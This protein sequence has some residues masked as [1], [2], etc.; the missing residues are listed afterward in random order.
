MA[1][2]N[3]IQIR[4]GYS[5]GATVAINGYPIGQDGNQ[6][7]CNVYL[8]E[9]ELGYEIDTGKFKIGR[10]DPTTGSLISWCDL[11]YAGGGSGAGGII[12][13]SGIGIYIH[14]SGDDTLYSILTNTDNN[15]TIDPKDISSLIAGTS[16]SYYEI[17]LADNLSNINNI[18]IS[19][20]LSARSGIFSGD[21]EIAGNLIVQGTGIEFESATVVLTNLYV[22]NSGY[23]GNDLTV[24][25]TGVSLEGHRHNYDEIDGFCSGV[26]ECVSTQLLAIN[27]IQFT[28]A[29]EPLNTLTVA[30][31]GEALAQH[32]LNTTGFVARSGT[33]TYVTRSIAAGS[34][35]VVTNED[36]LLGNP[37][38]ALTG[39]VT[40]L[41]SVAAT[42]FSG[43][44]SGNASSASQVAT[45][46]EES[47]TSDHYLT[48]VDSNN[49]SATNETVYTAS[50]IRYIP[51]T[52]TLV[53]GNLSGVT[54]DGTSSQA[55]T[56]KTI[57]STTN[58]AYYL[59]FV[60][61]NNAS[62]GGYENLYTN[63]DFSY[64]PNTKIFTVG[65]IE[66]S[67]S[68]KINNK[69]VAT[70]EYVDAVKQGL[71]IKDSV[72]VLETEANGTLTNVGAGLGQLRGQTVNSNVIDGLTFA[73]GDRVLVNYNTIGALKKYNGIYAVKTLATVSTGILLERSADADE[74]NTNITPG[75]FTFVTEG[76]YADTGWVL[77]TDWDPTSPITLNV[78]TLA[79]SQFSAAGQIYDGSGL[80]K[81]GNTIH[82]GTADSTR[83]KINADSIDLALV[84]PTPSTGSNGVSFVQSVSVDSYGRTTGVT[85]ATVRDATTTSGTKGIASFNSTSFSLSSGHVSIAASGISNSQLAN[86][87][88]NIGTD[89]ISLGNSPAQLTLAGLTSVTSTSFIGDLTGNADSAT[90]AT[91]STNAINVD[92]TQKSDN[93]NYQLVFAPNN[94]TGYS[95]L[96]IEDSTTRLTYN[97]STQTLT[98]ANFAGTAT[99]AL[100]IEV[101]T[102]SANINHLVF[103]N[104]TDGNL[105]PV[106]NSNLKFDALNNILYGTNYNT[107]T[108]PT[109]K[110]E[111]FIIDGGTP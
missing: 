4:R 33:N 101:D 8:A 21:V 20:D 37:T 7:H 61:S 55:D 84:N 97:P 73:I 57:E 47:S 3:Q 54:I 82:V 76:T 87:S 34:N 94:S 41:T 60:D 40:G 28:Y 15:I 104:G 25:G 10:K 58:G 38:V 14:P 18:T 67:T 1:V 36:G 91:N 98:C 17:G 81:S 62:P 27:G 92:I 107:S 108:T 85:T 48:F 83:I 6:W 32:Q 2:R 72:R 68:I 49:D 78:N 110:I 9:G 51:S 86:S 102:S 22:S 13:G 35:I 75:L 93:A 43:A 79:F 77:T 56:I 96:S 69:V 64:N 106:V 11:D 26:S 66:A 52:N 59:T 31:S 65:N 109:S 89:T 88:I 71:D 53:V 5:M 16:G 42:T 80:Y 19:G 95:A 45:I 90:S 100:N 24:G 29:D 74:I 30:L 50:G 99:N 23:F 44:L 103:V 46:K 63:N 70:Q 12:P 105:K 111:Y 39:V